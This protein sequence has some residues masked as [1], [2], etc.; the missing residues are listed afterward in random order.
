[1]QSRLT[2]EDTEASAEVDPRL[3]SA[4]ASAHSAV[5]NNEVN[6][7]NFEVNATEGEARAATLTTRRG[8]IETPVFM[9]VGTAGTVKGVRF[10][11]LAA[12]N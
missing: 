8:V 11:E 5:Q 10:E 1:M 2:T 6:P 12:G 9:P 7:V 4:I 3:S